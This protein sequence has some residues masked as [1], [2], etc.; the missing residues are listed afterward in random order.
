MENIFITGI[1]ENIAN[2][3]WQSQDAPEVPVNAKFGLL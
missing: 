3:F 1:I 2:I